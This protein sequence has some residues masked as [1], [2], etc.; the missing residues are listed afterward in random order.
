MSTDST[1]DPRTESPSVETS[2]P[3]TGASHE[4]GTRWLG[5]V[6]A[7]SAW[8]MFFVS[9]VFAV[10]WYRMRAPWPSLPISRWALGLTGLVLLAGDG[11]LPL[12]ARR[13]RR[14]PSGARRSPLTPWVAMGL[15]LVFL[16]LQAT[17]THLAWWDEHL[18]IPEGGVPASAFYGL[19]ALHALHVVGVMS[20]FFFLVLRHLRGADVRTSLRRHVLGWRFVSGMWLLLFAA[21]YLP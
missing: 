1:L 7:W 9:L 12:V 3:S 19:T 11:V 15:G 17:W 4:E 16:A 10:G 6:L 13:D 5:T 8:A 20:G 2:P 18:R 14:E 21:V